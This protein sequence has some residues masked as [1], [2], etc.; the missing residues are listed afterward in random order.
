MFG[1][2]TKRRRIQAPT[3][4]SK[5][6]H[7]FTKPV[8]KTE[9]SLSQSSLQVAT[10]KIISTKKCKLYKGE[11]QFKL[12]ATNPRESVY[13]C[14]D[15][16]QTHQITQ[17]FIQ[18]TIP[19]SIIGEQST[20]AEEESLYTNGMSTL[21]YSAV[22]GKQL[23]SSECDDRTEKKIRRTKGCTAVSCLEE[24]TLEEMNTNDISTIPCSY[25]INKKTSS[26]S[27]TQ[28]QDL[29]P[30]GED[31]NTCDVMTLP[32][33]FIVGGDYKL[34]ED[35]AR[36]LDCMAGSNEEATQP[37]SKLSGKDAKR[38]NESSKIQHSQS[39]MDK[40][41]AM[42]ESDS[43][44]DPTTD[45]I[46]KTPADHEGISITKP[47][48]DEKQ[49]TQFDELN[50]EDVLSV[51]YSPVIRVGVSKSRLA[52]RRVGVKYSSF[53]ESETDTLVKEID[54]LI[55]ETDT[56]VEETDTL[57]AETDTFAEEDSLTLDNFCGMKG[58][59][60]VFKEF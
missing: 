8:K 25:V 11:S 4:Q 54:T 13:L 53:S 39:Y 28:T 10:G 22:I 55:E 2:S 44:E 19:D 24:E 36:I 16:A 46:T 7:F 38:N 21:P 27:P 42:F 37:D 56:L 60:S 32:S 20:F 48:Q 15:S 1:K 12:Q 29:T 43:D 45:V 9:N 35:A 58:P 5:L 52:D 41:W 6:H 34:P 26:R 47:N 49:D 40:V 23:A 3:T 31:L 30:S 33:S 50:T 14:P 51:E 59:D 17:T 57:V 18:T